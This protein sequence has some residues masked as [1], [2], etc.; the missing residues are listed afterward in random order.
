MPELT[1]KQFDLIA[2]MI[3]SKEPPKSAAYLVLVKGKT[4][5]EA[6]AKTGISPQS[7]SN[8]LGRYRRTHLSILAAYEISD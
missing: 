1:K 5:R 2:K 6:M 3:Q 4:N 7:L 8:T